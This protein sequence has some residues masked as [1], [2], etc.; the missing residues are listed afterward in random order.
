MEAGRRQGGPGGLHVL[1]LEAVL[2][3]RTPGSPQHPEPQT[4]RSGVQRASENFQLSDVF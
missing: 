3:G 4:V 2:R 1:P